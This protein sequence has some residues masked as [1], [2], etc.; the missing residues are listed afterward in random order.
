MKTSAVIL[1]AGAGARLG[2]VAKALLERRGKR[3]F[4]ASIVTTA[5]DAG[6]HEAIVVV[7]PPFG[8]QV[9]A[10]ASEL[11]A[12]VVVNPAPE[13]G[14]ASSV[15]LGF[16][17]AGDAEAAWLWPVDHPD[18][19]SSTLRALIAAIGSHAAARPVVGERRGHPPL[20][21][22][23]LFE[24]LAGCTNIEGGARTVLAAADTVDVSVDDPGCVRD[25]DTATDLEAM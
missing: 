24:A 22:R 18:V 25:I 15:A 14:M 20:I 9:G 4:L 17:A 3:T 16:A 1:A 12:R 5:R 8:D 7:G 19:A 11:G 13:R 6:L 21:R 23:T 2:G 10:H